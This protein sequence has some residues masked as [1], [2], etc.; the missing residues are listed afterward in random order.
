MLYYYYY[1]I[2]YVPFVSYYHKNIFIVL[3]IIS[4]INYVMQIKLLIIPCPG[5]INMSS[6]FI[7]NSLYNK[8]VHSPE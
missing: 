2:K 3:L 8:F 5:I 7:I 1:A 4:K 6:P